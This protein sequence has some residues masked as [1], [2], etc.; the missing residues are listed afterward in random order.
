LI[1][2]P[3]RYEGP[4]RVGGFMSGSGSNLVRLL[5][6]RSTAYELAFIF[7]DRTDGKCNGEKIAHE[8]G[9][10]YFAYDI[11]QFHEKRG[12]KRSVGSPEGMA[13]RRE[14]DEVAAKLVEAFGVQVLAL[15]G[16]MSFITLSGGV[17]VHPA[18]L[19]LINADGSRSFVGDYAVYDAV[20]A[21]CTELRSS[22]L[23]IDQGVDTGPLLMVS[24]P[25]PV[26]LPG[27][28]E[29]LKEDEAQLRAVVDD[30][31]EQLKEKGDWVIFPLTLELIAT[32]RMGLTPEGV[33]TLDGKPYPQGVRPGDL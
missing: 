16:Y 23:W 28:L 5:E 24:D 30:L 3:K 9:I 2:D 4:M 14:F 29:E 13:A 32:G 18:D 10:P 11:R 15:G 25:L 17:N 31:Q 33:V 19:S 6:R 27:P 21:G 20:L 22:T 12:L 8:W 7:S 26:S 1:F